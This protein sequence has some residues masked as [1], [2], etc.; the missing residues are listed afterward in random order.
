MG[1][2]T[3]GSVGRAE[4]TVGTQDTAIAWGSGDVPVLGTPRLLALLEEATCDATRGC[5][6][7]G[8]TSVGI[9]VEIKHRRPT[10]V[11]ALVIASARVVEVDGARI[12][13]DVT[14]DHETAAGDTVS[15]V[16]RGRITRA[17]VERAS[18]GA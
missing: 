8:H 4:M 11:G 12:V 1:V 13:F 15:G 16:A 5:L 7:P 18:F 2:I 3:V 6:P 14:A 17:V 9:G 10:P